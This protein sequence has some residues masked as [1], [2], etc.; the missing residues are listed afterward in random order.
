MS[1]EWLVCTRSLMHIQRWAFNM[2][3]SAGKYCIG[4]IRISVRLLYVRALDCRSCA[5][6]QLE[7]AYY[8][9]HYNRQSY[10]ENENALSGVPGWPDSS[11]RGQS[12]WIRGEASQR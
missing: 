11:R 2:L 12:T 9:Q 8:H 1:N 10:Q 7:S 6:L 3:H 4:G 5:I